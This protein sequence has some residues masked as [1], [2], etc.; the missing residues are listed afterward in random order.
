MP[1]PTDTPS[2]DPRELIRRASEMARQD[3]VSDV[4][5]RMDRDDQADSV[6]SFSIDSV[7]GP[8]SLG[9]SSA[10]FDSTNGASE[11]P[12]VEPPSGS[13]APDGSWMVSKESGEPSLTDPTPG[14]RSATTPRST[15]IAT[16]TFRP[17]R[18]PPMA[19]LRVYDDNQ[20]DAEPFRLRQTPFVIGRQDGDLVV[21]HERQ[22][23]RRH[24][25]IDRVQEGEAWRWYLGDLRSTNGTFVRTDQALLEDG[26]EVLIGGELVRFLESPSGGAPSLVKV[27]P[28]AEEERVLLPGKS[29]R[30][31]TDAAT[32]L[33]F[34]QTNPFLD[35]S[36]YLVE[37]KGGRW[38]LTDMEST[39]H[40]WVAIGKRVELVD[41]SMFQIGEQRFGFHLP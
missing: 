38:R 14:D 41:G 29:H 1:D 27:A 21:G 4:F 22:M 11:Q 34:M 5:A 32:C 31:G 26:V 35:P 16:P 33:A 37:R 25:R 15:L 19:V 39:N 6:D 18:R 9:D 28:S 30:I 40:L 10:W 24:A 36:H 3:M 17:T 7:D 23:S 8:S 13:F 12:T 20:R 2:S